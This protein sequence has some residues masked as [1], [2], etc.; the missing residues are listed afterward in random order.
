MSRLSCSS[1]DYWITYQGTHIKYLECCQLVSGLRMYLQRQV[2]LNHNNRVVKKNGTKGKKA[3]NLP[4]QRY[5][6]QYGYQTWASQALIGSRIEYFLIIWRFIFYWGTYVLILWYPF[7]SK[8][9]DT[10]INSNW[11]CF[12]HFFHR[13]FL[14][15]WNSA[16]SWM[17]RLKMSSRWAL[18]GGGKNAHPKLPRPTNELMNLRDFSDVQSFQTGDI[19]FIDYRLS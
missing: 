3:C 8:T 5:T 1:K 14:L 6:K 7:T 17:R 13:P 12:T 19:I 18:K 10:N 15:R 2:E 4:P 9:S 11:E 16:S